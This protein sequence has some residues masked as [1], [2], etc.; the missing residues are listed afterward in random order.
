MAQRSFY[1]YRRH[2]LAVTIRIPAL[3]RSAAGGAL[4]VELPTGNLADV[5]NALVERLPSLGTQL[6]DERGEVR[7]AINLFVNQ[8][9]VRFRGG[10]SAPLQDGDEVY[11]V[12]MISG[13][14]R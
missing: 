8:E 7:S 12:P 11:I 13:G 10:L 3:W 2:D 5:L 14:D 9:H 6:F 4:Q 1:F